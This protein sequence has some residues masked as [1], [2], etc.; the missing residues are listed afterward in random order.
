MSNQLD[1][2]GRL[3]RIF[4]SQ[5]DLAQEAGVSSSYV[6]A[7]ARGQ[8]PP[9]KKLMAAMTRL[10]QQSSGVRMDAGVVSPPQSVLEQLLEASSK[11]GAMSVGRRA[12]WLRGAHRFEEL[13]DVG[14][15]DA[16]SEAERYIDGIIAGIALRR[17]DGEPEQ[18]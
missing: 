10:E 17:P 3:D 13:L 9:S 5:A 18:K 12:V 6:S 8:R 1:I 7:V 11:A 15:E 4:A 2:A 16:V 14:G